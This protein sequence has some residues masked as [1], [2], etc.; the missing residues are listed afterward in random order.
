V[1]CPDSERWLIEALARQN[2]E[3]CIY[4]S[5]DGKPRPPLN[6]QRCVPFSDISLHSPL[7]IA[8][9]AGEEITRPMRWTWDLAADLAGA[10]HGLSAAA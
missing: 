8:R 1:H 9:R 4:W 3:F 5:P 6:G 10:E 2:R 7:A